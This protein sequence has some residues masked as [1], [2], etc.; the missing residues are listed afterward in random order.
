MAQNTPRTVQGF[1]DEWLTAVRVSGKPTTL[2][3]WRDY[4]ASTW[5][6]SSGARKLQEMMSRADRALYAHRLEK[7]GRRGKSTKLMYAHRKTVTDDGREPTPADLAAVG[8][9]SV[10]GARRAAQ[11]YRP[12]GS[13]A[14]WTAG[15]GRAQ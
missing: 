12:G 3:N 9:V 15:G 11:R 1:F 14:Q 5:S 8:G 4:V 10:A 6:R 7:G 13:R 2:A